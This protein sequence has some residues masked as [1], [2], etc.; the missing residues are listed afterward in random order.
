MKKNNCV[1]FKITILN[2]SQV[3]PKRSFKKQLKNTFIC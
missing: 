3:N 1:K 2:S